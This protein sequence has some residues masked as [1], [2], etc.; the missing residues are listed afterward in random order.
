MRAAAR[1]VATHGLSALTLDKIAREAAMSRGHVRH[2]AGNRD[3]LVLALA[4]R[5]FLAADAELSTGMADAAGS[6]IDG[7]LDYLFS[8]AFSAPSEETSL[9]VEFLNAARNNVQLRS[10]MRAGYEGTRHTIF[11]SLRAEF[12]DAEEAAL[13]DC[14][15]ALLSLTLG[16]ALLSDLARSSHADPVVRAAAD[17]LVAP[18]RSA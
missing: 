4:R 3:E 13:Q 17:Q 11:S 14:A 15:Y 5:V 10:T 6:G 7:V 12:A 1:C 9:I 16:N 18:F 2:H 8:E